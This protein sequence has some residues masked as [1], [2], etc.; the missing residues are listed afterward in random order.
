MPSLRKIY[1]V[2]Y[3]GL[4]YVSLDLVGEMEH[5]QSDPCSHSPTENFATENVL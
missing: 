5:C 3:G 4:K 1:S 2:E